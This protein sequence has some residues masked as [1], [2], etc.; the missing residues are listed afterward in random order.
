[1][2][3][4]GRPHAPRASCPCHVFWLP[5]ASLRK[6]TVRAPSRFSDRQFQKAPSLRLSRPRVRLN[7]NHN[8]GINISA[9]LFRSWPGPSEAHKANLLTGTEMC[10][11]FFLLL[12]LCYV[13]AKKRRDAGRFFYRVYPSKSSLACRHKQRLGAPDST[14]GPQT[15]DSLIRASRPSPDDASYRNQDG[16]APF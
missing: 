15:P 1:M 11:C 13:V 5:C 6:Q 4:H 12:F 9:R 14:F 10:G 2:K 8:P 16:A 7:R 3:W